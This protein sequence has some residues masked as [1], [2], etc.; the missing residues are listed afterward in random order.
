MSAPNAPPPDLPDNSIVGL[1]VIRNRRIVKANQRLADTLGYGADELLATPLHAL[2]PSAGALE[3]L[4]RRAA[5]QLLQSG[6]YSQDLELRRRDGT[7]FWARCGLD[8]LE[9]RDPAQGQIWTVL[10]I[11][12]IKQAE[13]ALR[14]SA[15]Q[16]RLF[17]DSVPAMSIVYDEKLH[18]VFANKRFAEYFGLTTTSIV[19]KHLREIVGDEAYREIKVHFDRVLQGYPTGYERTRRL[20]YGEARHLEVKLIPHLGEQGQVRGLF[21]VTSDV[22]ERKEEENRIRQLAEHDALTGIANR[23]L[24]D[25]HLRRAIS[26]GARASR[27]VALLYID[28][29]NFKPVNDTLGHDVGDDLLRACADRISDQVR[30][31]DT[32]A[33]VGGD[34]FAVILHHVTERRDAVVVAQRILDALTKPFLLG[35]QEQLA[36]IGASI[37]VAIYPADAGEAETLLKAADAAMYKAKKSRNGFSFPDHP[38]PGPAQ[39]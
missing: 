20:P 36:S 4:E 16:L 32:V 13:Q 6:A 37:G 23:V 8:A 5:P 10:D 39:A 9:R 15:A 7:L 11:G 31:S 35:P 12:D 28:L 18:C 25:E 29:D 14:E 2:Y 33:R 17:A 34:E 22:T 1:G 26:L 21:A 38:P 27:P 3:A 24:F 19:G 30:E